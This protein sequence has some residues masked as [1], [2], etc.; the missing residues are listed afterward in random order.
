MGG[1]YAIASCMALCAIITIVATAMMP[2][3]TKQVFPMRRRRG[4]AREAGGLPNSAAMTTSRPERPKL[5]RL[6]LDC[7]I[8]VA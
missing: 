3:Y 6:V 4:F 2:D 8:A 5:R 7:R 1:L